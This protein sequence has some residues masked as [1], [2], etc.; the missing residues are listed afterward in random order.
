MPF[1]AGVSTTTVQELLHA[2]DYTLKT[3]TEGDMERSTN[4]FYA[5]CE[6]FGLIMNTEKTVVRPQPPPNTAKMS[7]KSAGIETQL[8]VVGNFAYLSN[9]LSRTTKTNDEVA[10]RIS[11]AILAFGR[12]QNTVWN[13]RDLHLITKLK[14]CKVAILPTSLYGA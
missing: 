11:K 14:M 13:R 4:R 9:N 6:K 7:R 12:L 3:T 8:P 5:A 2:Y 1:Q 10:R